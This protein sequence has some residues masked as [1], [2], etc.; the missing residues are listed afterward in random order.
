MRA[1]VSRACVCRF[2][3]EQMMRDVQRWI[4]R[5][6][7]PGLAAACAIA[8]T[9]CDAGPATNPSSGKERPV[10]EGLAVTQC[11]LLAARVDAIA[12]SGPLLLRSYDEPVAGG[13][14]NDDALRTA[15]F[16]YDN[17]LAV[18]ALTAC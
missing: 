6:A 11:A 5:V 10:A 8:L 15:A 2:E 16:S 17:A 4:R 1:V 9:A 3:Q 12:G 18:I 7:A 13:I 14:D